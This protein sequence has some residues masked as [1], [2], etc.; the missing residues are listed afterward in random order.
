MK[1]FQSSCPHCHQM[2]E[3]QQ[4]WIGMNAACP[5]CGQDFIIAYVPPPEEMLPPLSGEGEMSRNL[6]LLL[7]IALA[8]ALFFMLNSFS[9]PLL[10]FLNTALT[11]PIVKQLGISTSTE[12]RERLLSEMRLIHFYLQAGSGLLCFLLAVA[13]AFMA[14]K[15]R[16]LKETAMISLSI[17]GFSRILNFAIST[18]NGACRAFHLPL[19]RRSDWVIWLRSAGVIA[20]LLAVLLTWLAFRAQ[21]KNKSSRGLKLFA[22]WGA[23]ALFSSYL[24]ERLMWNIFELVIMIFGRPLPSGFRASPA[25]LIPTSNW[26]FLIFPVPSMLLALGLVYCFNRRRNLGSICCLAVISSILIWLS[27]LG[28]NLFQTLVPVE[29]QSYCAGGLIVWGISL[30]LTISVFLCIISSRKKELDEIDRMEL[31]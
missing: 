30:V 25:W 9:S 13:G 17:V 3:F 1:K 28:W 2:L 8:C 31:F 16:M 14:N 24:A 4:D 26:S 7:L 10:A 19:S 23:L 6:R 18:V 5:L 22:A 27:W 11:A 12:A 21:R 29:L 15:F 20:V